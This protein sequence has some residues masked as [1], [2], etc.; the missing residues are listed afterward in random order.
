P[1]GQ[2]Q[3]WCPRRKGSHSFARARRP[4]RLSASSLC[5]SSAR[6]AAPVGASA[7]GSQRSVRHTRSK[8]RACRPRP[9]RMRTIVEPLPETRKYSLWLF[10]RLYSKRGS[11]RSGQECRPACFEFN[12]SDALKQLLRCPE[13]KAKT[14][15]T[16]KD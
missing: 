8:V 9:E 12:N 3:C 4:S 11:I 13:S 2:R 1:G 10:S 6:S 5:H 16:T 7:L 15:P 14:K